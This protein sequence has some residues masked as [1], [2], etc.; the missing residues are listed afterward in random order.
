MKKAFL[1]TALVAAA[2]MANAVDVELYGQVNKMLLAVD[3]GENTDISVADTDFSST[4]IGFKGAETL[5]N[6][7][8]VSVLL[9]T[10]LQDNPS[11]QLTQNTGA[12]NS[13]TPT[14][15]NSPASFSTRHARVGVAGDFGA[16]FLGRQSEAADG[17]SEQDLAGV[18]NLMY[19]DVNELLGQYRFRDNTGALQ[20]ERVDTFATNMDGGRNNALRYDSPVFNGFQGR[21]S[22]SQGGDNQVGVFYKGKMDAFQ[23]A[24]AF[25]YLMNN[26]ADG[27]NTN[28][29]ESTMSG[30]VS[31]KHDSGLAGAF[32]YGQQELEQAAANVDDPSFYYVKGGYAWDMFEVAVDYYKSEDT[33]IDATKDEMTS[34]GLGAQMNLA[35]G[36]SVGATY[37]NYDADKTGSN[38]EE[39]DT[40]G[41]NMRVKF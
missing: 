15:S 14:N 9:E 37:R 36:V 35:K 23:I 4:R 8:T 28:R 11:D 1:T 38:F 2:G 16:V 24:A 26:D 20:T 34:V 33:E 19:S 31:V 5:D 18:R 29:V 27:T 10:E 3:D 22:T 41:V 40:Y 21:I 7:L 17:S 12:G 13:S 25:G 32:A 6:G 39:I 30:S